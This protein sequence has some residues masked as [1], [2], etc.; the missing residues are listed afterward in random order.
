[1]YIQGKCKYF[2]VD[3]KAIDSIAEANIIVQVKN[4][5]QLNRLMRKIT[6]LKNIDYV[7]RVGDNE[8]KNLYEKDIANEFSRVKIKCQK[9]Y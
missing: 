8:N 3:I 4:N 5:R 9:I 1:M 2:S 7:Q 6:K